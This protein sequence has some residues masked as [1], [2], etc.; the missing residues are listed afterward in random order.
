MIERDTVRE[1]MQVYGADGQPLGAV[2]R[3]E[4]DG[5]VVNGQRHP[6]AAIA[7]IEQDRIYLQGPAG[8]GETVWP[9]ATEVVRPQAAPGDVRA[10]ST[11]EI[12]R[13]VRG[14]RR[15]LA[16][17]LTVPGPTRRLHRSSTDRKLAGV[18]GGIAEYFNV[19]P[20]IVRVLWVVG[21]LVAPPMAP[22]A[23]LLYVALAV[24]IPPE[25][26]AA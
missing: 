5:L 13:A 18:A 11:E 23:L 1:G 19:D 4:G 15:G 8:Q 16:D 12:E 24:I 14:E 2:E 10:P 22:I 7:R 17:R 6:L 25:P 3:L 20:T 9:R 26:P 21:G